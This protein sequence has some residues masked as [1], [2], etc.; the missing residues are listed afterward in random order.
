[1][2]GEPRPEV[3]QALT[4]ALLGVSSS[5]LDDLPAVTAAE[6]SAAYALVAALLAAEGDGAERQ[7]EALAHLADHGLAGESLD[8]VA[9]EHAEAWRVYQQILLTVDELD[10]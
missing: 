5:G 8:T 10:D 3:V 9:R 2:S 7:A 4:S 1:M 6:R